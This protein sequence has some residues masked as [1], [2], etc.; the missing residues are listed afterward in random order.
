MAATA[1]TEE[2]SEQI[3]R[4]RRDLSSLSDLMEDLIDRPKGNAGDDADDLVHRG[5]RAMRSAMRRSKEAIS[6]VEGTIAD[7]PWASVAVA[8]GLGIVLGRLLRR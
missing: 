2:L 8:F 5:K 4:L 3:E 7:N 6:G 1:H